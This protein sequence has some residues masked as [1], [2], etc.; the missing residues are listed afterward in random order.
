MFEPAKRLEINHKTYRALEHVQQELSV[1]STNC[2]ILRGTRIVVP[3]ILQQR[4]ID[5][6]H[7]GHQ[8]IA[9]TMSL[10]RGKVWFAGI[11]GAVEKKVKSCMLCQATTS[12]TTREPLQM[13][14][15]PEGPSKEV[16]VDFK[17]LSGGGYL[18]VVYDDYSRYPVVEVNTSIFARSLQNSTYQRQYVQ[19]MAHPAVRKRM[20]R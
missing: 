8:G 17:E 9:K 12:E 7:E 19:T 13:S 5:L 3:E 4:V 15:L 14:P 16:S 1:C 10:L 11:D 20:A 6:A 2:I 18:L